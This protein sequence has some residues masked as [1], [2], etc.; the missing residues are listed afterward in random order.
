MAMHIVMTSSAKPKKGSGRYANVA[1]VQLTQEYTAQGKRP[2]FIGERAKGVLRVV[3]HSGRC[4]V[5]KTDK[6]EY[7]RVLERAERYAFDLNNLRCVA[8]A[9]TLITPGSA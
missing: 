5:G 7:R 3:W 2:K 1:V 8:D 4:H 6:C 9:R